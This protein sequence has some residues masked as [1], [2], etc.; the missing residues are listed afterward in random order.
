MVLGTIAGYIAGMGLIYLNETRTL[1]NDSVLRMK[2][3]SETFEASIGQLT[4]VKT[5]VLKIMCLSAAG[6]MTISGAKQTVCI[7][8]TVVHIFKFRLI[9]DDTFG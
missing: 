7:V 8:S 4:R 2:G 5:R 6:G 9:F 1:I 3:I